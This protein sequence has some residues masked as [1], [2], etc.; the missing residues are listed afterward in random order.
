L[1]GAIGRID[2]LFGA[3]TLDSAM[4]AGAFQERA[5]KILARV[6]YGVGGTAVLNYL[7]DFP[8]VV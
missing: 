4:P 1:R 7:H 2:A 6:G 8:L 5:H 3:F